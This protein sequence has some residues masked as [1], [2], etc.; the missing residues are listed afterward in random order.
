MDNLW[1]I[2]ALDE[3]FNS[4]DNVITIIRQ[5]A[6]YLKD[7]TRGI[8]RAKFDKLNLPMTEVL[9]EFLVATQKVSALT[10]QQ[11]ETDDDQGEN[12]QTNVNEFYR[13]NRYGFEIY[14]DQYRFRV[15]EVVISP[16]YPIVVVMDEGVSSDLV[17]FDNKINNCKVYVH[18]DR[19]LTSYLKEI[20]T[21]KKVKY[22]LQRMLK[23][24]SE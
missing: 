16:M 14:N 6:D 5:Q 7:S 17:L 24:S 1:E 10:Q 19:E 23:S 15:F 20:F 3:D 18:N 12:T 13:I 9:G 11:Y 22:I 4:T 21:T 2:P 8:I